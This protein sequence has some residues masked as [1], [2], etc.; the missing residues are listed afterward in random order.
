MTME[1]T[2]ANLKQLDYETHGINC[3]LCALGCEFKH[4]R[5]ISFLWR[6]AAVEDN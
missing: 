6:V 5:K 1:K 2:D 4:Q 3:K